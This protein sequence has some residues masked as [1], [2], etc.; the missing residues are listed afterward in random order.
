PIRSS[1]SMERLGAALC[2]APRERRAASHSEPI[3]CSVAPLRSSLR[4]DYELRSLGARGDAH[5]VPCE[6]DAL[7]TVDQPAPWVQ[8]PAREAVVRGC[9]EGVVVVVPRLAERR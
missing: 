5:H 9:R 7:E 4:F 8:L 2:S 1:P 3:D 6:P